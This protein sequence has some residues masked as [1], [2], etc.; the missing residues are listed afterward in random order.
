MLKLMKK[1]KEPQTEFKKFA[2]SVIGQKP[3]FFR[4][5]M[6]GRARTRLA[7]EF[8]GKVLSQEESR[9]VWNRYSEASIRFPHIEIMETEYE[10]LK[11]FGEVRAYDRILSIGSGHVIEEAVIAK[12]LVPQGE[13]ICVDFAHKM[14]ISAKRTKD[15]AKVSN[16]RIVTASGTAIPLRANSV[17]KVILSHLGPMDSKSLSKLFQEVKRVLKKGKKT[18]FFIPGVLSGEKEQIEKTLHSNGFKVLGNSSEY[19]YADKS[20]IV[21]VATPRKN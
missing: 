19:F 10:F 21:L 5:I 4:R 12:E 20:M 16:V 18:K 1:V 15:I 6:I 3:G 9:N 17:D 11:N 13:V 8:S 7:R 2:Q 14:N